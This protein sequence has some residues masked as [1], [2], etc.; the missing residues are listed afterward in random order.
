M[1]SRDEL[2]SREGEI[3][4]QYKSECECVNMCIAGRTDKEYYQDNKEKIK[5]YREEN[6]EYLKEYMKEYILDN[7]DKIQE[8]TKEYREDNK[9]KIKQ[10]REKNKETIS[11][12]KKI[13]ITCV[14][15]SCYR[16]ADKNTH[17]RTKKHQSFLKSIE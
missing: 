7:K 9:D 14:C 12:K 17:E 16:K 13:K 1:N 2:T 3:I 8:Y 4:R 15:G 6:K 10:Y 5:Q 11:E